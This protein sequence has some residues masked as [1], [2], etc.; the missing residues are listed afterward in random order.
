MQMYMWSYEVGRQ[1]QMR[2]M[3]PGID[4]MFMMCPTLQRPRS[5]G[6]VRLAS[7]DLNVQPRIDINLLAEEQDMAKMMDGVRR[8][9]A[10]L[11]SEPIASLTQTVVR[12]DEDTV[13]DN[14][15]LQ[16]YLRA[17]V[18]HLVHPVGTCKMGPADDPMAVVDQYGRVHGLDGLR[19]AD[20]AIMPNVPR[21]NTNLS[22]I[23]IG[24]RVADFIRAENGGSPK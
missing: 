12:P 16:E 10:L 13:N 22:A 11:H 6:R 4:S 23:M 20:A 9:W 5:T 24:E 21:A 14:E 8:A 1:P 7:S 2:V 17:S 18:S 15:K 19:V 3:M